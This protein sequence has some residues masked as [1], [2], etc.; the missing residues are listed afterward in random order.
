MHLQLIVVSP[1][2][3]TLETATG[4]FGTGVPQDASSVMMTALEGTP[5]WQSEHPAVALPGV[6]VI[7]HEGCRERVSTLFCHVNAA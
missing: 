1:L 4:V 7:A 6:P 5:K 2:V 3:R